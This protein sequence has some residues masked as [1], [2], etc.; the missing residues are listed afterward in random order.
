[1]MCGSR[2]HFHHWPLGAAGQIGGVAA[3]QHHAFD[4][5]GVLAGAGAGRIFARRRQRV[6]MVEGDRRRQ[7]YSG[8]VEPGDKRLQ[9]LAALGERQG[10]QIG[11]AVAEQIIGAQMDRIILHQ[12]RRN[13]FAVEALLQD[14]ETLHTPFAHHQQLAV[15]RAR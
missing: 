9:P 5:I 7:V 15:D 2:F 3:L 1:M 8:I 4:R 11:L 10:A 6:P 13:D 12:L 14:V